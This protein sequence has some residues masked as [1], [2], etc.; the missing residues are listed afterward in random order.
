MTQIPCLQNLPRASALLCLE[1]ERFCLRQLDLTRG[2]HLVVAVSGGADSTALALILSLLAPRLDLHLSALSIN[3]GLRPEAEDDAAHAQAV[4]QA[5]GILCSVRK[6]D[7]KGFAAKHHVGEEEAGRSIRYS[8]LEE[9]RLVQH[10]HFI[11]LGH[12]R[13]DLSEDVLLRLVRGAGWPSLGGM[14]ARDDN[15]HLLR[16]LLTCCPDDLKQLLVQCE[17]SWREDASNQSTQYRRNRLRLQVL[18]LLRAENPAL[19]RSMGHMWQLAGM[20]KDYWEKLLDAALLAHPWQ[21]VKQDQKGCPATG[22]SILL[23]RTLLRALHPAARLRLYMR[24]VQHLCAD[25]LTSTDAVTSKLPQLTTSAQGRAS[26]LLALD[27]ALTQGHGNTRFQ[28][29]G[30][31]EAYLKG[32]AITFSRPAS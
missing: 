25:G 8:L 2:S 17:L 10:A 9:E 13:E 20:D 32:G 4:C 12:H 28:L 30:G 18:P 5:L 16:P 27:E 21:K 31:F 15:R 29:P 23:P 7:V 1:V 19:D 22:K 3:H 11:A 6:A 14:P 24:A 26:T